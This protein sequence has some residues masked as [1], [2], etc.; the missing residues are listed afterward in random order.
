MNG[1]VHGLGGRKWDDS[2]ARG[3]QRLF[4]NRKRTGG[5]VLRLG[6]TGKATFASIRV[7]Y[8]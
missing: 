8:G 1:T 6:P 7:H 4:L 2:K 3:Q 5:E